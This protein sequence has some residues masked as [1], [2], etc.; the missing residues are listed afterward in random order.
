[1][2]VLI[3][4]PN[5]VFI[6]VPKNAGTSVSTWLRRH[7]DNSKTVKR[8]HDSYSE[9]QRKYGNDLGFSFAIVRNPWDRVVSSY[10]YNKKRFEWKYQN[11]DQIIED[12]KRKNSK[13][14]LKAEN[15]KK[16]KEIILKDDFEL[17]VRSKLFQPV[18]LS[19]VTMTNGVQ[20]ILKYENLNKD[21]SII[22]DYFNIEQGLPL[23]NT[24]SHRSYRNYYNN[25]TKNIVYKYYKDDI[26]K[27][28][29]EF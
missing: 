15:I 26:K 14:L 23:K 7:L 25:E 9:I 19:Q 17:Y 2:T 3:K 16:I 27:W 10:F 8:K 11:I 5:A 28:K 21:F 20:C 13:A 6:H 24:S 1:M 18:E 12:K 29:Y 22:Q 4:N